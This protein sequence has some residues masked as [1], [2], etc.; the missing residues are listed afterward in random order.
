MNGTRR[1]VIF[2]AVVIVCATFYTCPAQLCNTSKTVYLNLQQ[3]T[4]NGPNC[5]DRTLP[6]FALRPRSELH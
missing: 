2:Y 6:A 1:L 3:E 5:L 4:M